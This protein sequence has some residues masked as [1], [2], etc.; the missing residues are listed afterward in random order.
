VACN[1]G[2]A[3]TIPQPADDAYTIVYIGDSIAE[4]LIGPSPLGERDNYGYYALVGRVNGF[5]YYNHSVSGH[6][7]STGIVSGDGLL[8]MIS[9]EDENGALMRSHLQEADMI[10]IS[11]LG[12]N[13]LQYNLGLLMLEVA[14]PE[15][16][17]KYAKGTTLIN[18]LENGSVD[19]PL[20]RDSVEEF[21]ESG[22][23][24][25]VKFDFPPTYSDICNIVATLKELN[26]DTTIIFQ[27][28]YNPFFEGSKHLSAAVMAKLAEI[29]DDGRFGAEGEP[30]TTIEQQRALAD[31]LLSYL[32]GMLDRYLA[33]N[34][35]SITIIDANKAFNKIVEMDKDENGNIDLSGNSL[36]RKLI[37]QDWT[38]PSNLGHAI[39]AGLT[40]D[41]LDELEVSSPDAVSN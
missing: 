4:A 18:A 22:K 14:D 3:P 35:D 8:E 36:G 20:F 16:E 15:F 40:Q 38:H 32:N 39:I 41:L 23:P 17:A 6:K 1:S 27:K 28:V 12:N 37:Y 29:T 34:P 26:P 7:T 30:I 25:K 10:H 9:R 21:E 2:T 5:K 19:R 11:V 31:R 13:L 24:K 33:E